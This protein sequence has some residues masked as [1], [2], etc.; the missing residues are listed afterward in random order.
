MSRQQG[1]E[2]PEETEI[3]GKGTSTSTAAAADTAN[4][5]KRH[6]FATQRP[7]VPVYE[8]FGSPEYVDSSIG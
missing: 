1:P 8:L 2:E 5:R 7:V 6:T 4:E 3:T